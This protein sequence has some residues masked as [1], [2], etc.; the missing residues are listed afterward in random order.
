[1]AK[2]QPLSKHKPTDFATAE[3]PKAASPSAT[4]WEN[5]EHLTAPLQAHAEQLVKEAG[6]PELAKHAVDSAAASSNEPAPD[7][8]AFARQSGFTSY[9]DLFEASTPAG[10]ADGKNWFLTALPGGGWITWN[11]ADLTANG[12]FDSPED[13]RGHLPPTSAQDKGGGGTDGS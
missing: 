11:D 7:K 13:A 12:P 5:H 3:K 10:T 2:K 6:S 1:M 4:E 8:D 9:L